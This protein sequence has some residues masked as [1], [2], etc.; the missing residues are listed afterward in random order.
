MSLDILRK[1]GGWC[2]ELQTPLK[3]HTGDVT[4]IEIRAPT[5]DLVIRWGNYEISS[6]L[7]LLSRL[8][9]LPERLLRQL[10]QHDFDRVMFALINVVGPQIK[11]DI[12]E[13]KRLLAT[14]DEEL[15]E[16]QAIPVPDQIDPRF[17]AASGPVVRFTEKK[18]PP[19]PEDSP[20]DFAPPSVSEAVR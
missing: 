14:P 4:A 7:A 20:I 5:A 3:H 17:P 6:M 2:V 19:P 15:P 10:P 8:C 1:T 12:E 18:P 9:D 16:E 13:G 11:A